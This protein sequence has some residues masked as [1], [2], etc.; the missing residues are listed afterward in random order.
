[1]PVVFAGEKN[2]S[3]A[4]AYRVDL[5]YRLRT[6]PFQKCPTINVMC[7]TVNNEGKKCVLVYTRNR[8]RYVSWARGFA[9]CG[10]DTYC[11]GGR[12]L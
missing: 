3:H 11:D 10:G 8:V 6:H 4:R 9:V 12:C 7:I 5:L 1:M 2:V